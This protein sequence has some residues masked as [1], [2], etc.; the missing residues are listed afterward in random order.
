MSL[1]SAL[2]VRIAAVLISSGVALLSTKTWA[3]T[4]ITLRA[5]DGAVVYGRT[6]EWGA[7]DMRSRVMV[8]PRRTEFKAKLGELGSGMH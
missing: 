3:C 2:S 4:G 6:L 8:I 1:F 5:A 7:F